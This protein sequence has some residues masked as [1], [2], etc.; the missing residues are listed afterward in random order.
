MLRPRNARLPKME[1]FFGVGPHVP[2]PGF[3]PSHGEWCEW[4]HAGPQ[5]GSKLICMRCHRVARSLVAKCW[6]DDRSP[7]SSERTETGRALRKVKRG[8]TGHLKSPPKR[9]RFGRL[10]EVKLTRKELRQLIFAFGK[11]SQ[12]AQ[13]WLDSH[14]QAQSEV[15]EA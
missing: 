12:E 2:T 15:A 8:W 1:P 5:D 13:E 4:C 11:T 10:V 14:C 6:A 7:K 9:D 3:R